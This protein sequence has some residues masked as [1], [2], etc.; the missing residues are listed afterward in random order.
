MIIIISCKMFLAI[1][2]ALQKWYFRYCAW[3]RCHSRW[4]GGRNAISVDTQRRFCALPG[5]WPFGREI[6][7][8]AVNLPQQRP[9]TRSFNVF[10]D[11]GLNKRLSKQ[12]RHWWFETPSCSL[13]RHCNVFLMLLI[14]GHWPE[15]EIFTV[16]QTVFNLFKLW[17]R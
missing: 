15:F 13:W 14:A 10:F 11:R 5:Y 17:L 12:S 16:L 6:H 8:S 2:I 3:Y 9:L 1:G 7:R 4:H